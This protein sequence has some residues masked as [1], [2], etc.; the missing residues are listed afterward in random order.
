MDTISILII[1]MRHN[2]VYLVQGDTVLVICILSCHGL[3]LYQ[4]SRKYLEWFQ[5]NGVDTI[6][7]LIITMRHNSVY[8][9]QGDTVL[10]ICILSGHGLHLYQVSRK[11][12]DWFQSNGVDTISILII[13]MRHNSVYLVQGDT[14]L[15]T[16]ILSGHGF[17]LYQDSRKYLEP[18]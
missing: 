9:V 12:L 15:V 13:T 16:C 14:V 10:V 1:T 4:V 8:L 11:Y 3:Q 18:F 6:S 5:S 17:H 7:I 2:S